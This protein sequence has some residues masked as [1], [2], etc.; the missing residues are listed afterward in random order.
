[1]QSTR[2]LFIVVE[3]IDA[4]GST[5]QASRL[6]AYLRERGSRV[7]QTH[8]PSDGPAGMLIR[9]ALNRRLS[10]PAWAP[11]DGEPAFASLD[12]LALALLFAADRRDHVA[13][14]VEPALAHGIHVVSDRYALS[15]LA[16]QG[17]HAD[18]E[19]ILAINRHA[20]VPDLT[21]FLDLPARQA[22]DRIRNSRMQRD[23]FEQARL[24]GAGGGEVPRGHR[25]RP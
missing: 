11:E 23:A 3:G 12:P 1:M 8:E 5:T 21:V 18:A 14:R 20:P 24:P 17:L 22:D 19:W 4:S 9:L 25:Q 7:V 2:G 13:T 6:S 15:S 10:A 16:Y